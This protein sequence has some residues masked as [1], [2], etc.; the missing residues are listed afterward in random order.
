M[1]ATAV[2]KTDPSGSS[3][4]AL[5][6][7]RPDGAATYQPR[8]TPWELDRVATNALKGRNK[9]ALENLVAP[10]Q[11]SEKSDSERFPRPL[12]WAFLLRPPRGGHKKA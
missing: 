1:I 11:G 12:P 9:R 6:G 2:G 8:A 10:F 5:R 4:V 7:S 3:E